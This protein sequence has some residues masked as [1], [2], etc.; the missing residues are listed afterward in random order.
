MPW[1]VSCAC[2]PNLLF[3]DEPSANLD[4][5]ATRELAAH[6]LALKHRG[7]TLFIVDHRLYWLKELVDKVLILDQGI[8]VHQG[9]F[10][11]LDD[12]TLGDT[13]GLRSAHVTT[14]HLPRTDEC[15]DTQ[16]GG[17]APIAVRGLTFGYEKKAPAVP[18][19]LL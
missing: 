16:A 7:I 6:L 5:D 13:F 10:D 17:K 3:L 11:I 2:L 9:P 12:S 18:G 4:P 8:L 14:P 19:C 15:P 1:P